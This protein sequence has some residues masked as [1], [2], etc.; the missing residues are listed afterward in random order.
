MTADLHYK[1][2]TELSDLYRRKELK[3]SEVTQA[4]LERI[5]Q[6]DKRFNAYMT[7]LGERAL[8]QAE[9][10]DGEIAR[11]IDRGP[12]HGVPIGLK[13][14]CYTTFAPTGGGTMIHAKFVPSYNATVV[15]RLELGGAISIGKLKM[16]E[17]AYTSHHPDDAAPLNPW[18]ADHWVGSSSSGSG[19]ATSAGLCYGAIG[20]DTG[21]SIRFPSATCGLTGIKPTWGRVSRYGVFPLADSLDHVGPMCRSAADAAVMLGVI[22]GADAND[23]TALQAPVPNY[24]A[25]IGGGVRG[26]R[27]GVDRSYTQDGIDPQIVK[28]LLDAERALASLGASIREVKFPAYEKLVS[29][30]IPMC[31]VETAEA[32]LAT[33]PTR[34]QAY[35]PDLAQLIEQGHSMTGVEI[36]AIHHERLKFSGALAAMFEDID[37]LL[38]PT[39][40]VP[41]PTL[42][43]MGEYGADPNVL[44]NIL[45][46]TAPFDFSGSPTI[47]MPMGMSDDAMPLSF[48]LVGPHLSEHVLA[49]AGHAYQSIT[50]WHMR[51]PP[52]G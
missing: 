20:S 30:W 23:P 41:I 44:L 5:G 42:T 14:L 1:S 31:S 26:L 28:A 35:G 29:Q 17:G 49:R 39:M 15:D 21:G 45:R 8:R 13:D 48:Q 47:T 46:F 38:V 11:G 12:L 33:Y 25:Q 40:P 52:I 6:L 4:T 3:P 36:A 18:S 2:I 32:H 50:D 51:R 7:V 19:V 9:Q 22:A 34:K 37:L 43:K 24:L 16:T 27:I 10:A